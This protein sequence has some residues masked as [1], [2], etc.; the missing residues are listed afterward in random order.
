M[1]TL[2]TWV[3]GLATDTE[4]LRKWKDDNG[5]GKQ[6]KATVIQSA[7]DI[8]SVCHYIKYLHSKTASDKL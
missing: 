1:T 8:S 2:F 3:T 6:V 5:Y 7:Y 4:T